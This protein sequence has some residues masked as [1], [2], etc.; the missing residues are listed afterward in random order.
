MSEFPRLTRNPNVMTGKV[1]IRG[2]RITVEMILGQLADGVTID[3][4]LNDYSIL[5]REDILEAIRYGSWLAS[6]RE[7]DLAEAS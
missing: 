4:L 7:V 3:E 6:G 2:M 1:C 5:V